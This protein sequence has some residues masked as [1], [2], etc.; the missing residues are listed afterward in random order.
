M[1]EPKYRQL[2]WPTDVLGMPLTINFP[3]PMSEEEVSEVRAMAELWL[4]GLE[5]QAIKAPPA[6][7]PPPIDTN[8]AEGGK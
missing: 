5:R 3:D 7:A 8:E 4:R 1:S 2:I 6:A